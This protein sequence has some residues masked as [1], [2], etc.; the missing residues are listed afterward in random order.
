MAVDTTQSL[1]T[2]SSGIGEATV[3][4][5]YEATD[6]ADLALRAGETVLLLADFSREWYKGSVGTVIR[7]LVPLQ[8]RYS[9]LISLQAWYS[10][11]VSRAGYPPVLP[12]SIYLS[13]TSA[14]RGP[15][16]ISP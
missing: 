10:V 3:L 12:L 6:A 13:I 7:P 9:A 14:L 1:A 11:L 5:D 15:F 16:F 2:G 8:E 4:F